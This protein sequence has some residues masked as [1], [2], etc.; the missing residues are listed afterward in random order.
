MAL[1]LPF[2]VA[3]VLAFLVAFDWPIGAAL[4]VYTWWVLTSR[5]GQL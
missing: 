2:A 5:P 4:W 1:G 3:V